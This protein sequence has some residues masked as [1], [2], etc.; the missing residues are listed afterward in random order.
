MNDL[1]RIGKTQIMVKMKA[2]P[3]L[4]WVCVKRDLGRRRS[5][6]EDEL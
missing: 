4:G 2:E 3:A 1:R 5:P 6:I